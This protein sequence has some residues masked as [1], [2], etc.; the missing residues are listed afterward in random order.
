MHIVLPSCICESNGR[1]RVLEG[2]LLRLPLIIVKGYA[3]IKMQ[4]KNNNVELL[5][6]GMIIKE[7]VLTLIEDFGSQ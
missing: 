1:H 2:F 5:V 6:R 3:M 4:K 7:T